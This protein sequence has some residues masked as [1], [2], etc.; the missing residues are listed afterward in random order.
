MPN[1]F[2]GKILVD[3]VDTEFS[4]LYGFL[5]IKASLLVNNKRLLLLS[6]V[7]DTVV[8][9]SDIVIFVGGI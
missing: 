1:L 2:V 8:I 4:I 7:V 6:T 5:H 9:L 3:I